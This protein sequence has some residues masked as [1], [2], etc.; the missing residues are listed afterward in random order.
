MLTSSCQTYLQ[1]IK[2]TKCT[3]CNSRPLSL[4]SPLL[5]CRKEIPTDPLKGEWTR[6]CMQI[7]DECIRGTHRIRSIDHALHVEVFIVEIAGRIHLIEHTASVSGRTHIPIKAG[8]IPAISPRA[9]ISRS[10]F[11]ATLLLVLARRIRVLGDR[12]RVEFCT[13]VS[14]ENRAASFKSERCGF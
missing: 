6:V 11:A 1:K 3:L 13:S 4:S 7:Q 8:F 14:I 12:S 10:P 9:N 2:D 5:S